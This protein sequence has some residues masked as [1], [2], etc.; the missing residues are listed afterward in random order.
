MAQLIFK[1]GDVHWVEFPKKA[2][3]KKIHTIQEE[4]PAVVIS[5]D[6]QNQFSPVITVLP[7]TSQIDKTYP[8]E[9]LVKLDKPSKIL[10]DQIITIDKIYVKKKI[11]SLNE[12]EMR[13]IE[14]KLHV[15]LSLPC[16][17]E[18]KIYH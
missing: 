14:R 4:H 2:E 1:R 11:T 10:L 17:Q 18:S 7:A 5:N 6:K 15:T 3:K 9:V 8:F 13:E 16:Y 12:K